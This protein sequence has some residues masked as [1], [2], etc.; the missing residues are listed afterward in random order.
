MGRG[1]RCGGL[2]AVR[3]I[4]VQPDRCARRDRRSL[5]RRD[6]AL[7]FSR[8]NTSSA[9]GQSPLLVHHLALGRIA[10]ALFVI[11]MVLMLYASV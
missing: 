4:T 11:A 3:G 5:G 8:A 2:V 10:L 7:D 6:R 9:M 1:H